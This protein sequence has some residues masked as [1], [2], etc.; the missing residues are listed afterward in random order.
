[1]GWLAG[2]RIAKGIEGRVRVLVTKLWLRNPRHGPP[3]VRFQRRADKP[4]VRFLSL[5]A[6]SL[7]DWPLGRVMYGSIGSIGEGVQALII[8]EL[9]GQSG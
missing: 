7:H 4:K 2:G 1:M 8:N 5:S 6:L 9:G 3:S